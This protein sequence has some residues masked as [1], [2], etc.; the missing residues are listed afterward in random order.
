MAKKGAGKVSDVG[1]RAQE[2]LRMDMVASD[3][4]VPPPARARM[5]AG[6]PCRAR[7]RLPAR[8]LLA[9]QGAQE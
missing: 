8:M 7:N 4:H 5:A 3:P 6:M 1:C 2:I 9:G